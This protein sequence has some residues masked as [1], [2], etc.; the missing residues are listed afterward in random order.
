MDVIVFFDGGGSERFYGSKEKDL[1]VRV[2][3]DDR[4]VII[5]HYLD[6]N[7]TITVLKADSICRIESGCPEE[8]L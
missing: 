1:P 5:D 3:I 4:W 6:G 8:G 7:K 2:G